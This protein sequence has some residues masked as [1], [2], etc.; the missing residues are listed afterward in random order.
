MACCAALNIAPKEKFSLWLTLFTAD[1]RANKPTL[2]CRTESVIFTLVR[3]DAT[4]RL[5]RGRGGGGAL[6]VV[7]LTHI[8]TDIKWHPYMMVRSSIVFSCTQL[9]IYIHIHGHYTAE[10]LVLGSNIIYI[11]VGIIR[12]FTHCRS[13]RF[14]V[15][16]SRTIFLAILLLGRGGVCFI[17][18]RPEYSR[19]PPP[20]QFSVS[21]RAPYIY[22]TAPLY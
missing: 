11:Y 8:M 5:I 13:E 10:K 22:P 2:P 20:Q 19:P 18:I 7:G 9:T 1:R 12:V 16:P 17:F 3:N 21:K 15:N 4:M 6:S 14:S